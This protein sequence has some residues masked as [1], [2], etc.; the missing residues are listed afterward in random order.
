MTIVSCEHNEGRMGMC[1]ACSAEIQ[2]S[3]DRMS[4]YRKR[5]EELETAMRIAEKYGCKE[6]AAQLWR[7]MHGS[8]G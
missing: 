3:E 1:S 6:A 4:A 2:A 7:V 5:Q 8:A